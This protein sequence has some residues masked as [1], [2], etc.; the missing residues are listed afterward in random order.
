VNRVPYRRIP[1][2]TDVQQHQLDRNFVE[3]AAQIDAGAG[4]VKVPYRRIPGLD[5]E[6][7]RQIDRNFADLFCSGGGNGNNGSAP[8]TMITSDGFVRS[9]QNNAPGFTDTA[10]GGVSLPWAIRSGVWATDATG[11]SALIMTAG[12]TGAGNFNY[13][14]LN[15]ARDNVRYEFLHFGSQVTIGNVVRFTDANNFYGSYVHIV[16]PNYVYE[17][18]KVVAG[19]VTNIGSYTIGGVFPTGS[20]NYLQAVGSTISVFYSPVGVVISVTDTSITTGTYT[21]SLMATGTPADAIR[22]VKVTAQ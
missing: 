19:A 22:S 14:L 10:F 15:T 1:G 4:Q 20:T 3:A 5:P 17:L 16:G 12:T 21:G 6:T 11:G 18:I 7:Q 13:I 8:G 9:P 2:L